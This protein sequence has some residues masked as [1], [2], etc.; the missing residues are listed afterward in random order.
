MNLNTLSLPTR[1]RPTKSRLGFYRHRYLIRNKGS[2][3]HIIRAL[4]P[5]VQIRRKCSMKFSDGEQAAHMQAI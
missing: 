5:T 4:L 1:A 3:N 2:G